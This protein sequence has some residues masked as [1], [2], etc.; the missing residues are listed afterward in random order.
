[1]GQ[2]CS[3]QGVKPKSWPSHHLWLHSLTLNRLRAWTAYFSA[4]GILW[5]TMKRKTSQFS[6]ILNLEQRTHHK[7]LHIHTL[8]TS[9][10]QF[11]IFN[12]LPVRFFWTQKTHLILLVA[13]GQACWPQIKAVLDKAVHLCA[14]FSYYWTP[15]VI[16]CRDKIIRMIF[17]S[18]ISR[19]ALP[20]V[21][22][23][24]CHFSGTFPVCRSHQRY[25]EGNNFRHLSVKFPSHVTSPC[26]KWDWQL[27]F[28]THTHSSS[29]SFFTDSTTMV[30]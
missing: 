11:C 6:C 25:D 1:M 14:F 19:A 8:P 3:L 22:C 10:N 29:L 18:L 12:K 9:F 5:D 7:T 27:V 30:L 20:K 16:F 26:S 17:S 21:L 4:C 15:W 24:R 28:A 2:V 23:L 13:R